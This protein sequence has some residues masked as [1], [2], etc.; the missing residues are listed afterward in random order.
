[1]RALS[2]R[3]KFHGKAGCLHSTS[4]PVS[5]LVIT[6]WA[7]VAGLIVGMGPIE[8]AADAMAA[9]IVH[10]IQLILYPCRHDGGSDRGR[11]PA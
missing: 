8:D 1:M 7:A 10:S 2:D 4:A 6:G 3:F 5:I 11:D 9:F